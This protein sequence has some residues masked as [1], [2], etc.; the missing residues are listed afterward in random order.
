[1]N[2]QHLKQRL[3]LIDQAFLFWVVGVVVRFISPLAYLP[4]RLAFA[5]SRSV[6]REYA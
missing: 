6:S 2:T 5:P 3:G 1:M 4:E